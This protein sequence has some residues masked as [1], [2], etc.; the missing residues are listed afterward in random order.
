LRANLVARIYAETLLRLAEREQA[1][2]DVDAGVAKLAELLAQ[3][4]RFARFLAAPQ[5]AASAKRAVVERALGD[6]LPPAL[7]RFLRLVIEKHR[8][9]MLGEILGAWRELQ[10]V[11]ANRMTA[12]LVTAAAVDDAMREGVRV[13]LEGV[14]GKHVVLGVEVEPAL[15]GGV[16]IRFGDTVVDGSIR[17]RLAALRQ[18]LRTAHVGSTPAKTSEAKG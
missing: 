4:E 6:R 1:I 16:V 2:E 5:I 7:V 15:L 8:E 11:R 18:R 3:D 12:T 13:A 17:S 10:D 9:P 14:T